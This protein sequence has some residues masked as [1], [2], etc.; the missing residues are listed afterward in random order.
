MHAEFL[1]M[2]LNYKR[3]YQIDNYLLVKDEIVNLILS[4]KKGKSPGLDNLTADHLRNAHPLIA[5]LLCKLFHLMIVIGY[6]PDA[7]GRGILVPIPKSTTGKFD[8]NTEDFRGISL[9][10]IISKLFENCILR[11][12]DKYLWSSPRQFGFKSKSSCSHAIYSVRKTIEF[13]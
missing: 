5:E 3:S 10:P 13:F 9:N 7:F 2:K 6:V 1:R 4:L 8:V 11:I 12:F